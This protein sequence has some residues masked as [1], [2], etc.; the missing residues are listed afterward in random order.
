MIAVCEKF[1][2]STKADAHM[3][4]AFMMQDATNR[5]TQIKKWLDNH[6][7]GKYYWEM[8]ITPWKNVIHFENEDDLIQYIL[9]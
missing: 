4:E 5:Y 7:G 6:D 3:L 9:T 2:Y 1:K 8:S